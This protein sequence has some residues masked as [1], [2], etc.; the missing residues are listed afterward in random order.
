MKPAAHPEPAP[1]RIT[2]PAKWRR[3]YLVLNRA[4]RL[5]LGLAIVTLPWRLRIVLVSRPL[6]PLYGDFTDLLLFIHDL[7]L[8]GMLLCWAGSRLTRL[9][10]IQ[11]GPYFLWMPMLG[12]AAA[13]AISVFGSSDR[14]F[15]AFHLAQLLL[16]FTVYL[17]VINEIEGVQ[18][19]LW[20]FG[21]QLLLQ[22]AIV[23]GQVWL[24]RGVGLSR[25]GERPLD[26]T[27]GSAFVWAEGGMR[28]LRGYGLSDHP[29]IAA[30]AL[31]VSLM[32]MA[33]GY[34]VISGKWRLVG[35]AIICLGSVALLLTFAR[36]AWIALAF[37]VA[38]TMV[39]IIQSGRSIRI[40]DRTILIVVPLMAI[41]P[42]LWINMPYLRVGTEEATIVARVGERIREWEER[43]ALSGAANELFIDNALTGVGLGALPR[44]LRE[45]FPRFPYDYQP[46]RLTILNAA[47]ESGI[48]GAMFYLLLL[49]GPWLALVALRRRH[50]FSPHLAGISG[51]LML[52]TIF[53][54][55][56][57]YTW[58]YPSGRIWQWLVWGLWGVA[59]RSNVSGQIP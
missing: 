57:A 11:A 39:M 25:L 8:L 51:A 37:A 47:A 58:S 3:I 5:F 53:S 12:L 16:A 50:R 15:S 27:S 17:F 22:A 13:A 19:L 10:P 54:F 34:L 40:R 31:A 20:A 35:M 33:T 41:L 42:I 18:A 56:D 38:T 7:F 24:Q 28:S 1:G 48:I 49:L 43:R 46:A 44:A 14:T 23:A 52:L 36:S 9:R 45:S 26:P 32:V 4:A 6:T 59:Y 2:R 55:L 21:V 29:N 30:L